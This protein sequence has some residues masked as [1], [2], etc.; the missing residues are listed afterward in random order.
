MQRR[1]K[2]RGAAGRGLRALA[3]L[4]FLPLVLSMVSCGGREMYHST[5][6]V[7]PASW[8]TIDVDVRFAVRGV[9][10]PARPTE[11]DDV[12]VKLYDA[13]YELL[14]EGPGPAIPV[15]DAALQ[16]QE[17]LVVEACGTIEVAT[18]CQ[19][20]TL[21]ASPK[22]IRLQENL[23]YPRHGRYDRGSYDFDFVLERQVFGSD[24]WE[25]V[26]EARLPEVYLVA[27]VEGQAESA[28]RIPVSA[29]SGQ[30][31]LSRYDN[32]M[33]F[34]YRMLRALE[35]R[36]EVPVQLQLYSDL[37]EA[38]PLA[39][40]ERIVRHKTREQREEELERWVRLAAER[41]LERFEP[42]DGARAYVRDWDFDPD[43]RRYDIQIRLSWGHLF[44]DR[45]EVIGDLEVGEDGTD[46]VFIQRDL[47]RAARR[48]WRQRVG[49][50]RVVLGTLEW[51]P[52]ES[53]HEAP[54]AQEIARR[55]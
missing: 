50:D 36:N 28:I 25:P 34:E 52:P 54:R 37:D 53:D 41:L 13:D 46:A 48:P 33:E 17:R 24:A 26:P 14:Y 18:V 35:R 2:R 20:R 30:F 21:E 39:S 7:D 29:P 12:T 43:T 15:P 5:L 6:E 45:R 9:L 1:L 27:S 55:F 44:F 22:R 4:L 47:S 32:F 10:G 49:G 8:D 19:Q 38:V 3:A 23:T 51:E 42:Y 16:S 40:F 11:A 31:D